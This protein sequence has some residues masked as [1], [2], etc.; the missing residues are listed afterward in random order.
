MT[1]IM[2][3]LCS[4]LFK[5]V[6]VYGIGELEKN[7]R[8]PSTLRYVLIK[9]IEY[10][11]F[12]HFLTLD[13]HLIGNEYPISRKASFATTKKSSISSDVIQPR[14]HSLKVAR[15]NILPG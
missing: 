12:S 5:I 10:L 4:D 13:I 7:N 1:K 14:L 6:D 9:S 8:H 3:L 2:V 11:N 15:P